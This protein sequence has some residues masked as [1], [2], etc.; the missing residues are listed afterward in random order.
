[1]ASNAEKTLYLVSKKRRSPFGGKKGIGLPVGKP[2]VFR[3][4]AKAR[5]YAKSKNEKS[6]KFYYSVSVAAWGP[7]S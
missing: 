1:M 4:R 2:L 7:A 5:A 6:R 3:T